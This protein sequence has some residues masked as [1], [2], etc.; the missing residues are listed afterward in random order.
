M[1]ARLLDNAPLAMAETKE[2]LIDGADLA[3]RKALVLRHAA[4]RQS[5]EA[6]EGLA[7][8]AEKRAARW[9]R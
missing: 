5:A 4:K 3:A 9:P 8:F 6:R 7:A 2:M 1:T